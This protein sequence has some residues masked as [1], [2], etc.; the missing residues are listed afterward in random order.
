MVQRRS[1]RTYPLKGCNLPSKL[2]VAKTHF[3][4]GELYVLQSDC[5]PHSKALEVDNFSCGC[6]Q[7]LSSPHFEETA[8]KRI[9]LPTG[10][11][12]QKQGYGIGSGRDFTWHLVQPVKIVN[13]KM[14]LRISADYTSK[15][16]RWKAV[17]ACVEGAQI[18]R[19]QGQSS[20]YFVCRTAWLTIYFA[21]LSLHAQSMPTELWMPRGWK[22]IL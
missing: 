12:F 18:Q 2:Q 1:R 11:V 3:M 20:L 17:F 8:W 14:N 22:A 21:A 5:Y 15:V 9:V 6:Y 7:A 10:S 13:L 16:A 4:I 19:V